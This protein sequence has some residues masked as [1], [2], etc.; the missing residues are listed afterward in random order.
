MNIF[1]EIIYFFCTSC[2]P[3][4]SATVRY[5]FPLVFAVAAL[6]GAAAVVTSGKSYIHIES[7]MSSLRAGETFQIHVYAYAQ[8]PVNAVDISLE[9]PKDQIKI[10]GIDTG[11]SVITL[12]TQDPYVENNKVILRGGTFRRGFKGDH[13]IATIN[14]QAIETGLAQVSVENVQLLAGD[15]TGAQ[16]AVAK[17]DENSTTLYIEDA[18]ADLAATTDD[19]L[20]LQATASIVLITDID[21]DGAVTLTDISRFMAAW[22]SRSVTYDFNGD[23]KMSFRDF[24]IIL[25][26]SFFR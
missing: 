25:A 1:R 12:W 21:G 18:S 6:L 5:A 16:V 24:G 20:N 10:L 11:E 26:D 17:N 3:Q 15:G 2:R 8:V 19:G 23:G 7:S 9:F 13:L 14:A 22:S 4:K